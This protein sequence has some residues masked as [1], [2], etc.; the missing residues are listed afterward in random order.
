MIPMQQEDLEALDTPELD[1]LLQEELAKEDT[2]SGLVR[3]ISKVLRDRDKDTSAEVSLEIQALFDQFVR[4]GRR[5]TSHRNSVPKAAA[6]LIAVVIAVAF[7]L[8]VLPMEAQAGSWWDRITRWT[9]EKFEFISHRN[10]VEQRPEYVFQTDKPG[11]QEVYDAVA[12]LGVTEPVVPMWLPEGYALEEIR[13]IQYEAK[14]STYARFSSGD[15]YVTYTVDVY[16]EEEGFGY[17]T[18]EKSATKY[19]NAGITHYIMRNKEKCVAVWTKKNVE[20]SLTI[21]GSEDF[22]FEMLDS[23]YVTRR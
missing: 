3:R 12:A 23:I 8:T 20:C 4:Q 16:S 9:S 1:Q 10:S 17:N 19:E 11:L 7:M 18:D 14:I 2:D 6:A 5:E 21:D 15:K 22:I 13:Q